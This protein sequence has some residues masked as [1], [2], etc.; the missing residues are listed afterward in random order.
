MD[1]EEIPIVARLF[2]KFLKKNNV[3]SLYRERCGVNSLSMFFHHNATFYIGGYFVWEGSEREMWREINKKW[4]EILK[5]INYEEK[6][7]F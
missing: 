4:R 1:Q 7:V 2:I 6:N 5:K 3:Y